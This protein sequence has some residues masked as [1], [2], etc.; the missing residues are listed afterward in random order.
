MNEFPLTRYAASGEVNVAC[1]T[2]GEGLRAYRAWT[3]RDHSIA[4]ISLLLQPRRN[5]SLSHL[6]DHPFATE[7]GDG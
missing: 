4:S 6:P 7:G 5:V 1:Q 3:Y 2:M